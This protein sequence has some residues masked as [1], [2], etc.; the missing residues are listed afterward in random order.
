M[1]L[2]APVGHRAIASRWYS[3]IQQQYS[4]NLDAS[5][6]KQSENNKNIS[7]STN[8]SDI[9][10]SETRGNP[11]R[12]KTETKSEKSIK[13]A[14]SSHESYYQNPYLD[15]NVRS[16]MKISKFSDLPQ[17][18]GHNQHISIDNDLRQQLRAILRQFK[19]PIRY[20]FAYGSGVFSQ[21]TAS[22]NYSPQVDFIFGVTHTQHWHSLNMMHNPHHYS[23][24]R[25][26]GSGVISYIQ[27]N[28]GAGVYFNPFV[29][30]NGINLKYGVVSIDTLLRDLADW[31]TLYLAG[32]LHKPV[33]ILRDEPQ[34]R[35][36]NQANLIS[37]LRA[38]LLLLPEKFTE[39]DLYKMIAGI[40]YMGDPRMTFGE[41][42]NKVKNIVDNQFLNF[43]RLYSPLMD[44]L[45]NLELDATDTAVKMSFGNTDVQAAS[46]TQ[47]MDPVKRGNMVVR[48]PNDFRANLYNRY[49]AKLLKA[50][51]NDNQLKE[52]IEHQEIAR[53]DPAQKSVCTEFERRI[54]RDPD[55]SKE[56]SRSIRSTVAWP[57]VTQ[58]IKGVVTA[59]VVKSIKYSSEKLR[60]YNDGKTKS[61]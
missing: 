18:F 52:A 42:P 28:F 8:G 33:K 2:R 29:E 7:R 17:Y 16:Y 37:V 26:L 1:M 19:A 4:S 50:N 35:F 5:L 40:S 21:G 41:N 44:G 6:L 48:L 24:L 57:S 20:A 53:R 11:V 43:R 3:T 55:L 54:A 46:L 61:A 9:R 60:K 13:Q 59:G 12:I 39:Y 58:T 31:D 49:G 47:D 25:Y 36:V 38:S 45:P 14:G 15:Y 34:V 51:P 22:S 56:I 30:I 27:D 32:R 23:A 10:K